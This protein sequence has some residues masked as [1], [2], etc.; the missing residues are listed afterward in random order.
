MDREKILDQIILA[1]RGLIE[2]RYDY[3]LLANRK[4]LPR[5]FDEEKVNR[6]KHYFLD[7]I[8]PDPEKRREL[9]EAFD[10]LE[11]YTSQP[12]K[13]LSILMESARIVFTYGSSLPKILKA[14]FSALRSYQ[15]AT[16]FENK[17]VDAAIDFGMTTQVDEDDMKQLLRSLDQSEI[18]AF[19]SQTESL[20]ATLHD[21]SL[22]K[23]IK[24]IVQALID[25]MKKKPAIFTAKEIEGLELGKE[26]IVKGDDL[27]Q[28][29]SDEDQQNIFSFIIAYEREFL[30]ILR[31]DET[32]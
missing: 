26:I 7:F 31:M 22:V 21:R 28:E 15:A 24:T 27:F 32:T 30:E 29:L 5:T 9:N 13:L 1:Y 23:K 19:M 16:K 25:K 10:Q 2:K 4:D 12:K 18:E 6:F 17:L 3:P 8:Y 14:G 11:G 20:F